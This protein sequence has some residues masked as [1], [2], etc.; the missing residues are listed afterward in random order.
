MLDT[1]EELILNELYTKSIS[2]NITENV[3]LYNYYGCWFISDNNNPLK[4]ILF[5]EIPASLL[6]QYYLKK[7]PCYKTLKNEDFK[8]YLIYLVNIGTQHINVLNKYSTYNGLARRLCFNGNTTSWITT[9]KNDE[10]F[11]MIN[12]FIISN[13]LK[14]KYKKLICDVKGCIIFKKII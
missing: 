13:V 5:H 3:E 4:T 7:I 11:K 1:L 10:L 8:Q 9:I 2:N 12:S 6:E 14:E